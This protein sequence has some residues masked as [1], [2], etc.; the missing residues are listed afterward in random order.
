[1]MFLNTGPDN[2]VARTLYKRLGGSLAEQGSVVS[3][4]F[5]FG[6]EEDGRLGFE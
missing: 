6:S 5:Q 2:L 3:Y 4:W 1:M